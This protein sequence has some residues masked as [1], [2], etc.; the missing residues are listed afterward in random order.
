[1]CHIFW[2]CSSALNGFLK[3]IY[4][5]YTLLGFD[6]LFGLRTSFLVKPEW[7]DIEGQ[8]F[9]LRTSVFKKTEWTEPKGLWNSEVCNHSMIVSSLPTAASTCYH[10]H[11]GDWVVDSTSLHRKDGRLYNGLGTRKKMPP[12][13]TVKERFPIWSPNSCSVEDYQPPGMG[14][15]PT[16]PAESSCWRRSL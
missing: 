10:W 14:D 15:A 7:T 8:N 4:F 1:M 13:S 3:Y 9:G 16:Y 6:S 2:N 11:R 12:S 5:G